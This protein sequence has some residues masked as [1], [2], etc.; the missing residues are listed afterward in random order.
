LRRLTQRFDH[1]VENLERKRNLPG[2]FSADTQRLVWDTYGW[3]AG[4]E[5]WTVSEE[6]KRSVIES[7]LKP[8]AGQGH[9]ILE[10]GPGAG[11][12]SAELQPLARALALADVSA[13]CIE[14]CKVRLRDA[15]NVE[16]VVNDGSSLP[17]DHHRFDR[18]WSFDV[19][20]HIGIDDTA[21]YLSEFVRV[22]RSG[23]VALIHHTADGG[24]RGRWRSPMTASQFASMARKAG[25]EIV[26]QFDAWHHDGRQYGVA[27]SGDTITILQTPEESKHAPG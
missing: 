20:V 6:W 23:G 19:F 14:Q 10:I 15:S 24:I 17:F 5:E 4:G 27:G 7:L 13:T 16:F 8:H 12:W 1:A 2:F 21:R 11:R 9:D 18:I 25:L 3:S 22:L 26:S